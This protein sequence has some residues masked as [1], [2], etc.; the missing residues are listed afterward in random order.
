ML[1]VGVGNDLRG[2]DGIGPAVV[3]RVSEARAEVR[4]AVLLGDAADLVELMRGEAHVVIVDAVACAG[5]V[6]RIHRVDASRSWEGPRQPEGSTHALGVAEAIELARA[7]HCLPPRVTVFGIE[8]TRFGIGEE[9]SPEV[10]ATE[11]LV[12]AAVL[13]EME[14]AE[15][16]VA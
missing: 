10:R 8:G 1:V 2:D 16:D 4:V 12:V 7:L 6:G 14:R 5:E 9:P 15:V 3:R 11:D 13:G